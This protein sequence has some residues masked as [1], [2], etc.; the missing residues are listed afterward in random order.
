M[1]VLYK[2]VRIHTLQI[3]LIEIHH[4]TVLVISDFISDILTMVTK[5]MSGIFWKH[6]VRKSNAGQE[7][8]VRDD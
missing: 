3:K 8:P 6:R 7:G 5:N 2:S 1:S 4:K